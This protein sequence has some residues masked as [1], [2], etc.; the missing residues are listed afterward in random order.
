MAQ[1]KRR[2]LV[3]ALIAI[4]A[5][6]TVLFVGAALGSNARFSANPS[7]LDRLQ[8]YREITGNPKSPDISFIESP[9]PTC[10]RPNAGT[11]ACYIQWE[12]LAVSADSGAYVISM[13]V[14]IDGQLRAYHAGFFQTSMFIP[15]EM[16]APGYG[17][18]CG[19]PGVGELVGWGKTYP[20]TLEARDSSGLKAANRGIVACPADVAETYIPVI[21][22]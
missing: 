6:G 2:I 12:Y 5:I 18:V 19:F 11:G 13:T 20:Y 7:S 15:G 8:P 14:S 17:V 9:S 4:M 21:Q 10:S 22:K 16:T 1:P 3:L